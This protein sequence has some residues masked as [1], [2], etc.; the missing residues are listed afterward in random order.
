MNSVGKCVGEGIEAPL[1]SP[2]YGISGYV[3]CVSRAMPFTTICQ[4][5]RLRQLLVPGADLISRTLEELKTIQRCA[6]HA[7]KKK[8]EA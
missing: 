4:M 2:R 5:K 6:S 3:R 1:N 8:S 7:E